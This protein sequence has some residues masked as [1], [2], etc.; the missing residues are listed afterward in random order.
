MIE[1]FIILLVFFTAINT[2]LYF[3]NRQR[4]K[5]LKKYYSKFDY[6]ENGIPK[7][8]WK[9]LTDINNKGEES[10]IEK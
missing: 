4:K 1:L 6:V 2:L 9:K 7:Y 3:D 10:R 8:K 5:R